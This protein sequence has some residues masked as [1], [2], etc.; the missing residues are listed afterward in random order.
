MP[1]QSGLAAS[2]A[3]V[4]R[5]SVPLIKMNSIAG[6]GLHIPGQ[7][8]TCNRPEADGHIGAQRQIGQTTFLRRKDIGGLAACDDLVVI[9]LGYCRISGRS[10]VKPVI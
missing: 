3:S 10:V 9:W 1:G 5:L 4:G 2:L 8:R 7:G 6:S